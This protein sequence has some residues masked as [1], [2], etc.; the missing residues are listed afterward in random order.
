MGI[1]DYFRT[2]P[3]RD[4]APAAD[5]TAAS[6]DG[7]S[8][9]LRPPLFPPS[10]SGTTSGVV[11]SRSSA[12]MIDDIKHEVMV[13]YL[14]QQQSSQ[15]WVNPNQA[16]GESNGNEGVLLRKSKG[17]Y[18]ACPPSLSNSLLAEACSVLNVHVCLRDICQLTQN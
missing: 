8:L 18:M 6:Q 12:F 16:P 10:A 15:L 9:E 13:S 2:K 7:H 14:Y 5:P 4:N 3:P 1:R 17:H 11:S